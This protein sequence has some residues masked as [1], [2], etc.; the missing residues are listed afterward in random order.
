MNKIDVKGMHCKH[1]EM[2]VS[3]ELEDRGAANVVADA[4]TGVVT[5]E[6]DLSPE[7]VAEAVAAAGFELADPEAAR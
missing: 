5:F 1:C 7:Q 2:L 3:M 6:G 4:A